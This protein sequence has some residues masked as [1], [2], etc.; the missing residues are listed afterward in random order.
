MNIEGGVHL[1]SPTPHWFFFKKLFRVSSLF[2]L[3]AWIVC[4]HTVS[5][6]SHL[7][8]VYIYIYIPLSLM[9]LAG[10]FFRVRQTFTDHYTLLFSPFFLCFFAPRIVWE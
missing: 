4:M 3:L 9:H 7:L 2:Y 6:Y 8:L 5:L 10:F 1:L